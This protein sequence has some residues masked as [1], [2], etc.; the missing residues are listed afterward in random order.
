MPLLVPL[1]FFYRALA[2]VHR[3]SYRLGIRHSQRLPRPVISI[4]NLAIGGGGK[5][6][7]VML[8]AEWARRTGLDAAILSRGYGR[9]SRRIRIT[10]SGDGFQQVGDEPVLMARKLV[11]VPVAVSSDR[12]K[13]GRALLERHKVDLFILDDAF[14]H[15]AL[16]KDLEIV[17]IDDT[18]RLGNGW[19]LPA[20][21][22]REPPRR[23][24]DAHL[25]VVTKANRVDTAF[26]EEIGRLTPAP[27][28]WAQFR[29]SHLVPVGSPPGEV[30][31]P[32]EGPFLAFCGIANPESFKDSLDRLGLDVAVFQ[33]FP[34]HHPY[35]RRDVERI[36]ETARRAGAVAL[37]TTEKDAVRWPG[38]QASLPCFAL[39]MH[40]IILEGEQVIK[41]R[42][43]GVMTKSRDGWPT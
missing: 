1:S 34:D 2:A 43:D 10:G 8:V 15:H 27:V 5:T 31:T 7:M 18:R 33:D 4:G 13:A 17:V 35:S 11:G 36:N 29:P 26:E 39:V 41:E 42:L 12:S 38:S 37:V 6:P 22:L 21:F 32:P 24:R 9:K 3:W 14:S 20:G 25:I 23:L 40:L 19:T 30:V 28:V 16:H